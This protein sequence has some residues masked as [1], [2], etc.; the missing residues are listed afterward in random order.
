MPLGGAKSTFKIPFN[1]VANNVYF[2]QEQNSFIQYVDCRNSNF[3]LSS[4][5]AV[6]YDRYGVPINPRGF[7]FSFTAVCKFKFKK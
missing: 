2:Y 7:D 1:T 5:T 6:L 3:N 4:L